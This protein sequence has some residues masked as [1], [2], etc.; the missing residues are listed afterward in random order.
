MAVSLVP[1]AALAHNNAP[2]VVS[3]NVAPQTAP[4]CWTT[5]FGFSAVNCKPLVCRDVQKESR[6]QG[7]IR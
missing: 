4:D 5:N 7:C 3:Q 1:L 2:R 6:P